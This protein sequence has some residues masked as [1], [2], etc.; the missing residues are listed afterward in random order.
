[1]AIRKRRE[2]PRGTARQLGRRS[3]QPKRHVGHCKF[4]QC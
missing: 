3:R 1:M 4:P 2:P